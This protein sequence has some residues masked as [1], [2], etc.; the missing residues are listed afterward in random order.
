MALASPTNDGRYARCC[1]VAS[2]EESDSAN[3][4]GRWYKDASSRGGGISQCC[5]ARLHYAM[6]CCLKAVVRGYAANRERRRA[7]SSTRVCRESKKREY[8]KREK[9]VEMVFTVWA[10]I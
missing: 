1:G 10:E 4:D 9:R 8:G 3:R 2:R 7:A 5:L 6:I